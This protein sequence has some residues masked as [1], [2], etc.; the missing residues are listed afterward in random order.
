LSAPPPPFGLTNSQTKDPITFTF[1]NIEIEIQEN[2]AKVSLSQRYSNPSDQVI[3]CSF[4]FPKTDG[5]VCYSLKVKQGDS[6]IVRIIDS[7]VMAR[8]QFQEEKESGDTCVF[9]EVGDD[10]LANNFV[11]TKIRNFMP[12]DKMIITYSYLEK[13]SFSMNKYFKF[14]LPATL[15]KRYC[16]NNFFKKFFNEESLKT[17][18]DSIMKEKNSNLINSED[19]IEFS[20]DNKNSKIN[21]LKGEDFLS[22]TW[23]IKAV[24]N[25]STQIGNI[26]VTS[27]HPVII[28]TDKMLNKRS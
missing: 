28:I 15:T 23:I 21:Y 12:S 10:F 27:G 13:L 26:E 6:E 17:Q 9:T 14:I 11:T 24:I 16:R 20:D 22:Y 3:D 5:A 2:Y 8:A 18:I 1:L 4:N 25:F 19:K 7:K